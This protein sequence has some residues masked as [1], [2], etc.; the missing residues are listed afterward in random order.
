M[1]TLES[2]AAFTKLTEKRARLNEIS[3]QL[4]DALG[5]RASV[6]GEQRYRELQAQWDEAFREFQAATEQFAVSVKHLQEQVEARRNS[7][8]H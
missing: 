2:E 7:E 4:H 1:P 6:A 3:K 8:R 5:N